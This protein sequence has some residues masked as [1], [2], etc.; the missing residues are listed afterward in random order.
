MAEVDIKLVSNKPRPHSWYLYP[1]TDEP[2]AHA[3]N[4]FNKDELKKIIDIGLDSKFSSAMEASS[5]ST[6]DLD[7]VRTSYNSWIYS[8]HEDSAWIF[9][10]I[11]DAVIGLNNQFW[12]YDL[13]MIESLQ[14]TRYQCSDGGQHYGRH[15]DT[16][17][18]KTGSMRK[19][20]FSVQLSDPDSYDGGDLVFHYGAD[21]VAAPR[22]QGTTV[23]FPSW[24][25][26]EVTP[27]TQGTRYSLV[28]WVHG[29][30]FR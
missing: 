15:L 1:N 4:V 19:L 29:P 17:F 8:D 10:R 21:G 28:G 6:G 2:W 3:Q 18:H 26:H 16:L 9:R 7:P 12:K 25:L 11:T 27:V 30:N 20:S 23:F 5:I 22:T 13:T 24:M 14:F